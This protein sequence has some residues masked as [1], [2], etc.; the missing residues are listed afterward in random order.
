MELLSEILSQ[1]LEI[2]ERIST[3]TSSVMQMMH[4]NLWNSLKNE[5]QKTLSSITV[6]LRALLPNDGES[7]KNLQNQST[8]TTPS[9]TSLK[10]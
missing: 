4:V 7:G 5:I 1:L 6:D 8:E 2:A 9:A 10:A 3:P